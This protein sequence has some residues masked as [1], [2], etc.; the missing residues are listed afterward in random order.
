MTWT[1]R[2]EGG[3]WGESEML[4]YSACVPSVQNHLHSTMMA[5]DKLIKN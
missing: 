3:D 1:A 5:S 4:L 2:P